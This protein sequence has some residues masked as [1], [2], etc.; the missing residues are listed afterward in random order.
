MHFYA[1][2]CL[3]RNFSKNHKT[4]STNEE[5]S[6]ST[7]VWD[8]RERLVIRN[9]ECVPSSSRVVAALDKEF[10]LQRI[11]G[12]RTPCKTAWTAED[13]FFLDGPHTYN[14]IVAE[15]ILRLTSRRGLLRRVVPRVEM[16]TPLLLLWKSCSFINLLLVPFADAVKRINA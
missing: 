4:L 1:F 8:R 6:V 7:K 13:H 9:V 12:S 16:S 14:I 10:I 5:C 11:Q 2:N 15:W 3:E